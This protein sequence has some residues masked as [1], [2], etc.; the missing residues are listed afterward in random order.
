M[1]GDHTTMRLKKAAQCREALRWT[2]ILL[3]IRCNGVMLFGLNFQTKINICKFPF[4]WSP[5][6]LWSWSTCAKSKPFYVCHQFIFIDLVWFPLTHK[7]RL[8]MSSKCLN[9]YVGTQ[10]K[11]RSMEFLANT[12]GLNMPVFKLHSRWLLCLQ[13]FINSGREV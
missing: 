6:G 2:C 7:C 4:Q 8:Q 9:F 11:I 5:D 1:V 13:A 10:Y 3:E 12:I